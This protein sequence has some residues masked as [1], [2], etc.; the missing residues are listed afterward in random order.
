MKKALIL[1][2]LL[3][4]S[5]L[6]NSVL[7]QE[8]VSAG[9]NPDSPLH[10]LDRAMESIKLNLFIY[11]NRAKIDYLLEKADERAAEMGESE[12]SKGRLK[13]NE[14][15][16]EILDKAE[17][18]TERL[19]DASKLQ[20]LERIQKHVLVLQRVLEK[21]PEQARDGI[22]RA[23]DNADRHQLRIIDAVEESSG[24][25]I[26][27]FKMDLETKERVSETKKRSSLLN[28]ELNIGGVAPTN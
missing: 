17:K 4:I 19:D 22:Q 16:E 18:R 3:L 13:A 15:R 14:Q 5:L 20:I 21:V 23:I 9:I 26:E 12:T 2:S 28:P 1:F 6:S 25:P 27:E 7:A 10:S 24:K 11:N 8:E